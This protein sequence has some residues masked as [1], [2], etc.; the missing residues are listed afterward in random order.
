MTGT[1]F[2]W[3]ILSPEN[4]RRRD[5]PISRVGPDLLVMLVL[6]KPP[7]GASCPGE[8]TRVVAKPCA[9]PH[10]VDAPG[11]ALRGR[12]FGRDS[13]RPLP[14]SS[15]GPQR[16]RGRPQH[17]GGGDQATYSAS[18][19][20]LVTVPIVL[21]ALG[22]EG[23]GTFQVIASLG[24]L[25]AMTDI[26]LGLALLTRVGQLAGAQEYLRIRHKFIGGALMVIAH[27]RARADR[28]SWASWPCR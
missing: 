17:P 9:D 24:N 19:V 7:E 1:T 21:R 13:S 28:L 10:I 23:Y 18:I 4:I 14:M 22:T 2:G 6:H 11:G 25:A 27:D 16:N 12:S 20:S 26:G 8:W 3:P 15:R 5:L